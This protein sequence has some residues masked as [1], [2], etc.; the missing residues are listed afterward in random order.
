MKSLKEVLK[1]I[2]IQSNDEREVLGITSDSRSV[3]EGYIYVVKEG[4]HHFGSEFI[5]DALKNGAI[6]VLRNIDNNLLEK[7][8]RFIYDLDFKDFFIIGITGTNGKTTTTTL[9]HKTLRL[10][11]INS[12]L[13]GTNGAYLN[14]QNIPLNNTTPDLLTLY[15][16]FYQAKIKNIN[17]VIMEVSSH[18]LSLNRLGNILFDIACF[19][20]ISHDHLDFHKTI[21]NYVLAKYSIVKYLKKDGIIIYNYDDPYISK[22]D[23][24]PYTS[25]SYG[26][27][28]A[29][30]LINDICINESGSNFKINNVTINSSLTCLFNV[31]NLTLAY[32]CLLFTKIAKNDLISFLEKVDNIDGRMQK[33]I[34]NER[35]FYIDFAHSPD[36]IE[37]VLFF[38][39]QFAKKRIIVVFGAG[40]DRDKTKRNKMLNVT[41]KYADLVYVTSDNPRYEDP[42][43]IIKDVINN[44]TSKKIKYYLSRIDAIKN[45][46]LNSNKF[47]IIILLGKGNESYQIIKDIKIPYNEYNEVLKI[48]KECKI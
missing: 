6:Y 48:K 39:K 1:I 5:D 44:N 13:I 11:N 45:A 34:V 35:Y 47:D 26:K 28:N 16:L 43:I 22:L 29:N 46:Y 40:G 42:E 30:Y 10:N 3:K 32:L 31:Y 4:L 41:L 17:Y 20:N 25:I 23:F 38:I 18:S 27:C 2:N 7:L 8:A 24:K 19:T 12:L 9:I 15:D 36:A 33:V 21:D 37:K 14:E